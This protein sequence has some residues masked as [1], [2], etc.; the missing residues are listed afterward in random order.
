VTEL[1]NE[2]ID[3]VQSAVTLTLGSNVENLSL[4]GVAAINGT[5]NTLNNVLT[6]N[7][8]A[9]TLN[10]GTGTDTLLG[11]AGN[12]TYVVDAAADM[13]TEL[14]NEGTDLMQSTVTYTLSAHVENLTLTGS[15]AINGTGNT[16]DNT[17]TGNSA[18]NTLT[19]GTG[20]D[21]LDGGLGND[22]M[23]GGA[24]NDTYA[25]NVTTDVVTELANEG[26]DTV[27]STVTLTLTNLNL[28]NLTLTGSNVI[29]GSGNANNNVLIGNSANNT[30]TGAAGN[31]TL[32][33]GLGN[34]TMVGGAGNDIFVVNVATDVTTENTNEGTDTVQSAVAWTLGTNLENLALT[35]SNAVNGSGNASANVL[36]GNAA[37]NLLNG[38][39][40]NDTLDGGAGN[41]TLNGAG[42]ADTYLFA[43]GHGVDTVL[44]NDTTAAVKDRVQFAAGITQSDLSYKR[45]GNNL[46]AMIVGSSDKIVVQDWYLGTQYHVEEFRF[47]DGAVLTDTQVQNLVSA[48]ALFSAAG[49]DAVVSDAGHRM[50]PQPVHWAVGAAM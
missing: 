24:G 26:I 8:A 2:G 30:L 29:N 7:V 21:M 49:A 9:N 50:A 25:V 32:D 11:G 47:S 10:G 43:R 40:G 27:Q 33:G 41:D 45:V 39:A 4:T 42:G 22:T 18:N 46:E 13:V 19:A 16:L 15:N 1:T 5:G 35:G 6:G 34:D 3:T 36:V 37:A 23:L 14:A 28:E 44:D 20:N 17:L 31:D 12:D 38:L 48:M